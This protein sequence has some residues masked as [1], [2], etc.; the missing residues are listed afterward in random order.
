MET[1]DGDVHVEEVG[2][3]ATVVGSE[4]QWLLLLLLLLLINESD[5]VACL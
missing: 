3:K 2:E 5:Q 1:N 4:K